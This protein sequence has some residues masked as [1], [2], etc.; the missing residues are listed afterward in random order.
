LKKTVYKPLGFLFLSLGLLGIPLPVLPSTPFILLA[1]WFFARSSEKWHAW[2]LSSELF[3]PM[4]HNWEENRC[5]SCRT[6]IVALLAMTVAGSASILFAME[7]SRLRAAT[8]LLLLIGSA[9]VLSL[10]TCRQATD[11]GGPS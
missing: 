5:I 3:G 6:K 4:I 10:R 11:T 1:A 7:D 9:T 2:L 8:L